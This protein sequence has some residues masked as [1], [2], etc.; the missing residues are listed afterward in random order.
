MLIDKVPEEVS[1][2]ITNKTIL[3]TG[4]EISPDELGEDIVVSKIS[5][6]NKYSLEKYI[7]FILKENPDVCFNTIQYMENISTLYIYANKKID[8][9]SEVRQKE[10]HVYKYYLTKE[11]IISNIES[12]SSSPEYLESDCVS[13]ATVVNF[14][15]AYYNDYEKTRKKIGDLLQIIIQKNFYYEDSY[16]WIN[17][18]DYK[19]EVLIL[20]I[21]KNDEYLH[22]E[23][24]KRNGDLYITKSDLVVAKDEI[25]SS[26]SGILS[27]QY[28]EFMKFKGYK[29]RYLADNIPL[30][31]SPFGVYISDLS[32][33]L[34]T[35]DFE[36]TK[37]LFKDEFSCSVNSSKVQEVVIGKEREIFQNLFIRIQD[38]PIWCQDE[39]FEIRCRQ[40]KEKREELKKQET[41]QKILA[42]KN[43]DKKRKILSYPVK[44]KQEKNLYDI[45]GSAQSE[46]GVTLSF[47]RSGHDLFIS[48]KGLEFIDTPTSKFLMST[49][50]LDNHNKLS[51]NPSIKKN[52][53]YV[54]LKEES[55]SFRLLKLKKEKNEDDKN[56]QLIGEKLYLD[57]IGRQKELRKSIEEI[58]CI[59][60]DVFF[61]DSTKIEELK[62]Q[63]ISNYDEQYIISLV[64]GLLFAKVN[65]LQLIDVPI[66]LNSIFYGINKS[67][68]DSVY[69]INI[70]KN[71][72]IVIKCLD[73]NILDNK[74]Y[75]KVSDYNLNFNES[76]NYIEPKGEIN[77]G[78]EESSLQK[79]LK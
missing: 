72:E 15:T 61:D 4:V 12:L 16:A 64:K 68:Y 70:F 14:M 39:L 53:Y 8:I 58:P 5:G 60:Y 28:D 13:L 1:A 26:I 42:L 75:I 49:Y 51:I 47:P 77:N 3:Y 37:F 45:S 55:I 6:V 21:N 43:N 36:L 59:S 7:K 78:D 38:L 22:T 20:T 24:A 44:R 73:F 71:N 56:Y 66:N 46:L 17:E 65:G 9:M 79:V 67:E 50:K 2:N 19:K 23:F 52:K 32:V 11:E 27:S 54:L 25:F 76:K 29:S 30:H 31:N 62:K 10:K 33:S 57:D 69:V 18:F 34:R 35:C 74:Y 63:L 41:K 40:L 48:Q